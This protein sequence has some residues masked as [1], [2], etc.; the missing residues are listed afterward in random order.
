MELVDRSASK[1]DVL[2]ACGFE[3]HHPHL[4]FD[5]CPDDGM[6]DVADSKSVGRKAV[7]VRVSLWAPGFSLLQ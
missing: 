3:S 6:V 2:V 7:R 4:V 5:P 1:S